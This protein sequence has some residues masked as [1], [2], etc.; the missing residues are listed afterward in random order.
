MSEVYL[1]S[2]QTK[3]KIILKHLQMIEF[4]KKSIVREF[5]NKPIN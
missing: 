3:K 5:G 2:K 1:N 4:M